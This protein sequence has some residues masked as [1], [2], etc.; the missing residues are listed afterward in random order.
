MVCSGSTGG[1]A[2]NP[3]EVRAR[4]TRN[5]TD[6]VDDAFGREAED[7]VGGCTDGGSR[8]KDSF[9]DR[10]EIDD[11]PRFTAA[12]SR[13]DFVGSQIHRMQHETER[14]VSITGKA[15][16]AI[17]ELFQFRAEITRADDRAVDP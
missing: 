4:V 2:R 8:W 10:D 6:F 1:S 16:V 17:G 5:F 7:L 9:A 3:I 15:E 11:I 13:S 12:I 14:F